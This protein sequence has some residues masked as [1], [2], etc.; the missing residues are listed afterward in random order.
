LRIAQLE[1]ARYVPE[2]GDL[3]IAERGAGAGGMPAC[4]LQHRKAAF[5]TGLQTT[6]PSSWAGRMFAGVLCGAFSRV[7]GINRDKPRCKILCLLTPANGMKPR[8]KFP[9][10]VQK[11]Y[12]FLWILFKWLDYKEIN[13]AP[14]VGLEPTTLRLTGG[15]C[16]LHGLAPR[17]TFIHNKILTRTRFA[18]DRT[19]V[20]KISI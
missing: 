9:L 15:F 16:A 20:H 8:G 14:Q 7:P 11:Q 19:K 17:C 3:L 12:R 6:C 18:P 1:N 4:L 2:R 5:F 13:L 10:A